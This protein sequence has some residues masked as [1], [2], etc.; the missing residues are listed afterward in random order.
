[1]PAR[2]G[3]STRFANLTP[4]LFRAGVDVHVYHCFRGWSSLELIARQ[5]F[6][7]YFFPEDAFYK[8]GDLLARLMIDKGIDI[9]QANDLETMTTLGFDLARQVNCFRVLESHYHSS[10]LARQMGA[11]T[12]AVERLRRLE[13][14][15]ASHVDAIFVFTPQDRD[16]W[17]L[18]SGADPI[19][20]TVLP[21]GVSR[22]T[23]PRSPVGPCIA[24]LGNMFFEPNARA[25]RIIMDSILPGVR[26]ECPTVRL[27]VLGDVPRALRSELLKAGAEVLGEVVDVQSELQSCALGLAPISEGTGLRTKILDYLAAGLPVVAT[28]IAAEG[29]EFPALF[30]RDSMSGIVN[31]CCRLLRERPMRELRSSQQLLEATFLWD[32]IAARAAGVYAEIF[33][34]EQ[35]RHAPPGTASWT[36]PFWLAEAK[37][38]GRF[39][40]ETYEAAATFTYG[41]AGSGRI[42]YFP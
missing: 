29:L 26:K 19:K 36:P 1:M 6:D 39:K 9:L 5:E 15:I 41:L 40:F 8:S 37:E 20:L 13:W 25:L 7:T 22:T 16:R 10:T 18:L 32:G 21:C 11:S 38:K 28:P 12:E 4:R 3:A 42:Q 34:R 30:V 27:R 17:I 35:H 14:T 24:F 33:R 23:A 31:T 2:D